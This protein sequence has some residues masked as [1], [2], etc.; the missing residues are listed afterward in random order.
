MT[1]DTLGWRRIAGRIVSVYMHR[2]SK[3]TTKYLF[4]VTERGNGH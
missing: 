1:D 3:G 2:R 4:V